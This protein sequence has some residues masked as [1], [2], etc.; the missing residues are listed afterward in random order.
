[1]PMVFLY[2]SIALN[3]QIIICVAE[4]NAMYFILFLH[5]Y[6]FLI[7]KTKCKNV[8]LLSN[9]EGYYCVRNGIHKFFSTFD[10]TACLD[11]Y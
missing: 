6:Q 3:G 7:Y 2:M 8:L 4:K 1:M 9:F 10:L 5:F 11:L